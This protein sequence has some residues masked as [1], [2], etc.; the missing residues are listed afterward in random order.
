MDN[1]IILKL[2]ACSLFEEAVTC[3]GVAETDL[4]VLSDAKYVFRKSRRIA[5][6]YPQAI[7]DSAILIVDRCTKIQ[8]APS[9][10]LQE[11]EVEG[12]DPGERILISATKY[13]TSFYLT[14]G[15]KR[16]LTALAAA[17]QL[18]EI[19]QRLIGRVVCLEQLI[20]KLIDQ[21]G[22]DEVLA[23]VL[24]AREYDTA[25]KAIFGSGE[26]ATQESV[27]QALEGYIEDLR[28]RTEGLLANL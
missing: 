25:L 3:L 24:P 9:E 10:E 8:P 6:K 17:T 26:K 12:I 21:K 20:L 11:L 5:Q 27:L 15:D 7:R 16:C 1:D 13:E 4:R 23:K 22:F 19:R 28:K 18:V 14:T 2:V